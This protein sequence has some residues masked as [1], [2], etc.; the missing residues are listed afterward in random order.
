MLERHQN[1]RELVQKSSNKKSDRSTSRNNTKKQVNSRTL[2]QNKQKFE[3]LDQIQRMVKNEL[4][5]DQQFNTQ[6]R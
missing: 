2:D 1:R 5:L 4:E 6:T 3:E